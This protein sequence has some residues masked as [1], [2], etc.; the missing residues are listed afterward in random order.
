MSGGAVVLSTL[1]LPSMPCWSTIAVT[2]Y[3]VLPIAVLTECAALQATPQLLNVF[4]V[5]PDKV[6]ECICS[7]IEY[8]AEECI[9]K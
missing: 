8:H 5:N 2:Q 7:C 6:K 3:F 4:I 9:S 1:L